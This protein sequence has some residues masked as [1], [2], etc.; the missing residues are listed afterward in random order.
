M[1]SRL[2]ELAASPGRIAYGYQAVELL[3]RV[4]NTL[5]GDVAGLTSP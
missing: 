4:S 3:E 1:T 2:Q 5:S